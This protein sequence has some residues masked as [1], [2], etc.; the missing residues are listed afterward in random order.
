[1][2]FKENGGGNGAF[3]GLRAAFLRVK[4]PNL[5]LKDGSGKSTF[6]SWI[7]LAYYPLVAIN[8]SFC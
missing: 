4:L 6:S 5:D 3:G 7:Y 8:G 2:I 1:M